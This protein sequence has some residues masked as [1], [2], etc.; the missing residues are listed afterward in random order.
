MGANRCSDL[1]QSM[2][3]DL[4]IREQLNCVWLTELITDECTVC[5]EAGND[6]CNPPVPDGGTQT[7][8]RVVSEACID[9]E[10]EETRIC[11]A[12]TCNID[13]CQIGVNYE[14]EGVQCLASG[15]PHFTTFNNQRHDFQ[16]DL[17]NNP[18]QTQFNYMYPCFGN[19]F[20]EQPFALIGTHYSYLGRDQTG[21]D[22]VVLRLIDRD[23]TEYLIFVSSYMALYTER[24][25]GT[26]TLIED[27][28]ELDALF[29]Y[30]MNLK[31]YILK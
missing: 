12:H 19:T 5:Q 22:Y 30:Q 11:N 2:V 27:C 6:I 18:S 3:E 29:K 21:L 13:L 1:A 8:Q 15:D 7:R 16:G 4:C 23:Q 28:N 26:G 25:E 31:Y 14:I 9:I 24:T 10:A 17:R 20:E